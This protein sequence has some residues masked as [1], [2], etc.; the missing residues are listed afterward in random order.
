MKM[1][2]IKPG[3]EDMPYSTA[4][5]RYLGIPEAVP[6]QVSVAWHYVTQLLNAQD[7]IDRIV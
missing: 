1:L 2:D 6:E 7:K 4:T 3:Y 5:L